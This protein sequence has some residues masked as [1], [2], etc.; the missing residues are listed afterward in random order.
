MLAFGLS[1]VTPVVLTKRPSRFLVS[2]SQSDCLFS[3]LLIAP[4]SAFAVDIEGSYQVPYW[5]TEAT[6]LLTLRKLRTNLIRKLRMWVP[7]HT[8]FIKR[9]FPTCFSF[10]G[11]GP[12]KAG[13][14]LV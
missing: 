7:Q 6:R 5:A 12:A 11:T 8:S 3:G 10:F 1:S 4:D 9:F 14:L 13:L 2:F